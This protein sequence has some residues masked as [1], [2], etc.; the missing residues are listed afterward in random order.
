MDAH[1][2]FVN[3]KLKSYIIDGNDVTTEMNVYSALIHQDGL[4]GSTAILFDGRNLKGPVLQGGK[5]FNKVTKTGVRETHE[6]NWTKETPQI[7]TISDITSS[8]IVTTHKLNTHPI[9]QLHTSILQ[10][11]ASS[12]APL[13]VPDKKYIIRKEKQTS[14]DTN[15]RET[16]TEYVKT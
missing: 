3:L 15:S 13:F 16:K 9:N 5:G 4:A 7:F 8:E 12:K 1:F 6:F 2:S 14:K 11:Q 10:V